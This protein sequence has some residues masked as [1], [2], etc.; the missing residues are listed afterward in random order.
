MPFDIY[1]QLVGDDGTHDVAL[2]NAYLDWLHRTFTDSP[3]GQAMADY[4]GIF[5]WAYILMRG[6]VLTCRVNPANIQPE[7]FYELVFKLF[8]QKVRVT[9]DHAPHIVR[10]LSA[11]LT[12]L[13]REFGLNNAL[14]CRDILDESATDD[15]RARMAD[16]RRYSPAKYLAMMKSDDDDPDSI[17]PDST[18]PDGDQAHKRTSRYGEAAARRKLIATVKQ[19][20]KRKDKLRKRAKLRNERGR[21]RGHRRRRK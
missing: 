19:M 12:F 7:H 17:D 2:L 8:P 4:G 21:K 18:D 9:A 10:E 20:R 15:L 3:E 16:V 14:A 11:F 13:H 5:G 6:V 1:Q